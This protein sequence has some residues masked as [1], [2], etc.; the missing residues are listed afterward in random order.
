M[1]N[2]RTDNVF[3]LVLITVIDTGMKVVDSRWVYKVKADNTFNGR[4]VVVQGG[5][6]QVPGIDCGSTF[7]T[8]SQA[9]AVF[10]W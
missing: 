7:A 4:L 9:S 8:L 3:T 2:L 6:G 10:V 5:W 1:T